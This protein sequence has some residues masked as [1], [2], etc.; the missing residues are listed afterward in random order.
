MNSDPLRTWFLQFLELQ[1]VEFEERPAALDAVLPAALAEKLG[2]NEFEHFSFAPEAP[3]R[4]VSFHS[5]VL[6]RVRPLIE[7][8]G[9][10][11]QAIL[12]AVEGRRPEFEAL[13][14]QGFG[15]ANGVARL[16]AVTEASVWY[17]VV[18]LKAIAVSEEKRETLLTLAFNCQTGAEVDEIAPLLESRLAGGSSAAAGG[19]IPP[20]YEGL[21]RR[22]AARARRAAPP[23]FTDFEKSLTRRLM[24]DLQRLTDYYT[25]IAAE[26]E[27]KI[28]RKQQAGEPAEREQ[29]K[30]EATRQEMARKLANQRERYAMSIRLE[31][32][33]ALQARMK[34]PLLELTL[35]RRKR[36]RETS[37]AYNPLLK[38]IERP[39]CEACFEPIRQIWLCDDRVHLL[40]SGCAVC[41]T[42]RKETC[43]LCHPRGCPRCPAATAARGD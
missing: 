28:A 21:L 7:E 17:L 20:S 10:L 5:D 34:V 9:G 38:R 3:G 26:L 4:L 8:R 11:A 15:F 39:A 22:I 29:A 40:C 23:L 16:R 37:W 42:C 13:L 30:L 33:A 2:W 1:E 18:H 19:E 35:W 12:P 31:P 32:I 36:S 24:R 6:E 41:P 25:D 43:R 14:A 27:K